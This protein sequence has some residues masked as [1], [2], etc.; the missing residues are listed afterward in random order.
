MMS[1]R[2]YYI[3][4]FA[5]LKLN[6]AE[7]K[8]L[9]VLF[10]CLERGFLF[11][12]ILFVSSFYIRQFFSL[13]EPGLS[14]W[15]RQIVLS[16]DVTVYFFH[17][18]SKYNLPNY[19]IYV[20]LNYYISSQLDRIKYLLYKDNGQPKSIVKASYLKLSVK[21]PQLCVS[22]WFLLKFIKSHKVLD[23]LHT[24]EKKF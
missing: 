16:L 4:C 3:F 5:K 7:I 1:Q 21:I 15:T 19:Y 24:H 2:C 10:F 8:S 14:I 23:P 12:L 22:F 20:L 6:Q 17:S 11:K 18:P 13:A 9:Q